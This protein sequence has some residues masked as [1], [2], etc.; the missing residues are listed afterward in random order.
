MYLYALLFLSLLALVNLHYILLGILQ[1]RPKK[2]IKQIFCREMLHFILKQDVLPRIC[3]INYCLV[4][5]VTQY[6]ISVSRCF[7][8]FESICRLITIASMCRDIEHFIITCLNLLFSYTD[9]YAPINFSL[10]LVMIIHCWS[11]LYLIFF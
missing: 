4:I 5:V 9:V 8:G 7:Q 6:V 11:I 2:K 3:S 10:P 1:L